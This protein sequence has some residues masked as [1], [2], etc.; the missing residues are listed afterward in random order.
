MVFTEHVVD[1]KSG[2]LSYR[3]A[4]IG[5]PIVYLHSA[6][7]VRISE[8]L[9][10]LTKSYQVYV[11]TFPGFDGTPKHDGVDSKLALAELV[12]EFIDKEIGDKVDV[13]GQ[14]FGGWVAAW[15]GARHADKLDQ[16][17]LECPAGFVPEGKGGLSNDPAILRRQLY[18]FPDRVPPDEK[19]AEIAK[20][21]RA[22]LPHYNKG[23][24]SF[25]DALAAE[26]GNISCLTL[27]IAGNVDG[28]IPP[29]SGRLLKS[30]IPNSFLVYV[31]EA[32]HNIEIDQPKL[33][34]RVVQ[35]FLKWGRGFLVRR[36][37]A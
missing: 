28:V 15:L 24:K 19:S 14:S 8:P 37:A 25:D 27:I 11:P 7:G 9:E 22:L 5:A 3:V 29:D 36:N 18:A 33:F 20:Q 1:L 21:N 2:P 12:S 34:L 6:G 26:L 16:L 32:A 31:H 4:G 17:I 23:G 35:D 13:I 10:E 30:R